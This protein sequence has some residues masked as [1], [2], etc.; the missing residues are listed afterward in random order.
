LHGKWIIAYIFTLNWLFPFGAETCCTR[1]L[2]PFLFLSFTKVA[3]LGNANQA[4]TD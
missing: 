4:I 2:F 1:M 3:S